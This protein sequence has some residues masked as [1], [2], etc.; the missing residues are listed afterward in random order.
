M[1]RV[2]VF[3]DAGYLFAQGSLLI[4]GR[5]FSRNAVTLDNEAIVALLKTLANEK[6]RSADLLRIYWY[7][8]PLPNG[9]LSGQ[10]S[11]LANMDDVKLRLGNLN[12]SGQ[13]KGVDSLIVT[14]MID[15]AR[16]GAISDV[17]LLSGDEDIRIGVQIAQ[18]FGVRVHLLGIKPSRASQSSL[19]LRE[20]DTRTEW[21]EASLSSAITI[22]NESL[23]P[24][25]ALIGESRKAPASSAL[26]EARRQGTLIGKHEEEKL[27]QTVIDYVDTLGDT[28]QGAILAHWQ[29]EKKIL[30]EYDRRLLP[31]CRLALSGRDLQP[32]ERAFARDC[33]LK[34]LSQRKTGTES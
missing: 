19:L 11:A 22:K 15:L 21:S 25:T 29:M 28:A 1:G 27:R 2:A 26:P 10:Q 14:D 12:S 5:K 18:S 31:A 9:Q 17:V 32:T 13:Q 34:V 7:D 24:D 30:P 3:V 20:V 8:A 4:G 23:G 33:F 16:N 6:A